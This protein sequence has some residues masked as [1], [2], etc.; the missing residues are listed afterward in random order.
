MKKYLIIKM[1]SYSQERPALATGQLAITFINKAPSTFSMKITEMSLENRPRERLEREGSRS[2]SDAEL[3][4]IILKSGTKKENVLEISHKLLAKYGTQGLIHCSVQELAE[5]YGVGKAKSCQLVALCE[6]AKR[7][8]FHS[9]EKQVI[10]EAQDVVNF[11]QLKLRD[12]QK[13]HFLAL[14]LDTKHK[15]IA[16]EIITVGILNASLI[17]PREVF[18]AAI[19]HLAKAVIVLHN[20]PSGDPEPSKED[21]LVTKKLEKTGEIL[22][23]DFLD[24]IIIGK[25]TWWSWRESRV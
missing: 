14:Y 25:E 22:G 6:F 10:K 5:E 1:P 8:S 12:L 4:A 23:I 2:L 20:H 18:H 17:H 13:E 11:Y 15:L 9:P 16:E 7:L 3:I 19:K 24:H 21:L